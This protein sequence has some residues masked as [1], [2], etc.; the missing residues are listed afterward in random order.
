M[1]R[2]AREGMLFTDF[3]RN[4]GTVC[5][6]TRAGLLTG[7]VTDVRGGHPGGYSSALRP[8]S[9]TRA[10]RVRDHLRGAFQEAGYATGLVGK[11]HLGYAAE[12]RTIIRKTTALITSWA[13]TVGT[14]IISTTGA[15]T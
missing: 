5:S 3:H 1:D 6:S 12:N 8:P 9:T 15:I 13:I 4:G 11:W 14:S 7:S 2:L 10:C